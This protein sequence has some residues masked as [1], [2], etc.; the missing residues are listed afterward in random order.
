MMSEFRTARLLQQ[1]ED[2][3]DTVRWNEPDAFQFFD[4][5]PQRRCRVST[6]RPIQNHIQKDINI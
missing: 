2:G 5:T 6:S 1:V 3:R 4:G